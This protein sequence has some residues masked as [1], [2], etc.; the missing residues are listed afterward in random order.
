MRAESG[1]LDYYMIAGPDAREV[2]RRYTW[3]TGR[4]ALMPRWAVAIPDRP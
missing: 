1:D 4:P 3:L 2:T